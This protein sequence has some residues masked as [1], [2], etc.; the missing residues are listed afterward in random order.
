L[1]SVVPCCS[2][3]ADGVGALNENLGG[4]VKEI[5]DA[6]PVVDFSVLLGILEFRGEL[7]VD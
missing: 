3:P 4:G 6:E 5:D 7:N 1:S 2:P